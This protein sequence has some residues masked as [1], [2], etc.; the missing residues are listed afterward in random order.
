MIYFY[1]LPG[2]ISILIS[3]FLLYY[4][5]DGLKDESEKESFIQGVA[6]LMALSMVPIV[7]IFIVFIMIIAFL[8]L[9][10]DYTRKVISRRRSSKEIK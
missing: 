8:G 7:N 3:I 2:F 9:V 10:Y 5:K 1:F 6:N 4:L